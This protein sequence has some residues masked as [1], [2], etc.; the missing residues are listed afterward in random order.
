MECCHQLEQVVDVSYR[1]VRE[2]VVDDFAALDPTQ[3]SSSRS[4]AQS[5]NAERR[6]ISMMHETLR[7][8]QYRMLSKQE[9]EVCEA[10][11]P[12]LSLPTKIEWDRVDGGMLGI[13]NPF[14]ER[15]LEPPD[16]ADRV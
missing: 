2:Q 15:G 6:F 4:G 11:R 16:F 7:V 1:N 13:L 10:I 5:L 14:T 9:Q 12:A 8:S 3:K